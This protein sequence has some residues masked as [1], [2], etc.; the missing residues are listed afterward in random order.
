[1]SFRKKT[2]MIQMDDRS[3]AV[4][5]RAYNGVMYDVPEWLNGGF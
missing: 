4:F 3:D 5:Q 1:M 2:V